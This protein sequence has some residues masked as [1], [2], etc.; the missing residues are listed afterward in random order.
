LVIHIIA[1][2]AN[3]RHIGLYMNDL[4]LIKV[5]ECMN[6]ADGLIGR[7]GVYK[8]LQGRNSKKFKKLGLDHI[9]EFGVLSH[10]SKTEILNHV[11]YL[12]ERGCLNI[13]FWFFPNIQITDT[14]KSRLDRMLKKTPG[15]V[16][17]P[18]VA[19]IDNSIAWSGSLNILNISIARANDKVQ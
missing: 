17:A 9:S 3:G 2:M 8:L 5:L 15:S 16:E 12:I 7:S 4:I 1:G 10:I 6:H 18:Q 13:G 14:G 19:I 11:D